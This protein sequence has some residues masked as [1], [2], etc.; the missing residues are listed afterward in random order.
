MKAFIFILLTLTFQYSFSQDIHWEQTKNWKQYDI[1]DDN[2][3]RYSLDTLK[4]FK[5]LKL[6][7]MILHNYLKQAVSWPKE[8]NS[9]WMGLYVTTCEIENGETRKI[10]ISVYGGFFYDEKEKTYYALPTEINDDW[11]QYFHDMA[12]KLSSN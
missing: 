3:F 4:H 5:C 9:L 1:H 11:L 6:D 8:K 2:A 12:A 10:D 7:D